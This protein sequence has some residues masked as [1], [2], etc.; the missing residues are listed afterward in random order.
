VS[1]GPTDHDG[2]GRSDSLD[3]FLGSCFDDEFAA[4]MGGQREDTSYG[5]DGLVSRKTRLTLAHCCGHAGQAPAAVCAVSRRSICSDACGARC[6]VCR[7]ICCRAHI[8]L[9]R[10]PDTVVAAGVTRVVCDNCTP[11]APP[12]PP[13]LGWRAALVLAA[14]VGAMA[15][16]GRCNAGAPPSL[17]EGHARDEHGDRAVG[18]TR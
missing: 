4:H 7:R 16:I 17:H 2:L 13:R 10:E 5:A 6:S 1:V 11:P 8:R 15:L 14:I 12:P 18:V 9:L 3:D